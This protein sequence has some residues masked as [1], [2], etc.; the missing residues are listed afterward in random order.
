MNENQETLRREHPPSIPSL[1]RRSQTHPQRENYHIS[2]AK[3]PD[4]RTFGCFPFLPPGRP[5]RAPP[6]PRRAPGGPTPSS[7]RDA[8]ARSGPTGRSQPPGGGRGCRPGVGVGGGG[9]RWH[10]SG[11]EPRCAPC[12]TTPTALQKP[13]PVGGRGECWGGGQGGKESPLANARP[14]GEGEERV[15]GEVCYKNGNRCKR[16]RRKKKSIKRHTRPPGS[17]PRTAALPAPRPARGHRSLP[18]PWA[19]PGPP[20]LLTSKM[21]PRNELCVRLYQ[22]VYI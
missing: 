6:L 9:R 20:R 19:P 21:A 7:T 14:G 16:R 1:G 12:I 22:P 17:P 11:P 15:S 5:V 13:R 3:H 18:L 10:C 2:D 8:P 4:G